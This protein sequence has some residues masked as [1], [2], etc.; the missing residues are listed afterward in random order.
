MAISPVFRTKP[1]SYKYV[2]AEFHDKF[3][4][5]PAL[6]FQEGRDHEQRSG[7]SEIHEEA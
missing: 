6:P 2:M 1:G 5:N 3:Y 4:T 7:Q